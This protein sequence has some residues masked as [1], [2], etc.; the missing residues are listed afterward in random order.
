MSSGDNNNPKQPNNL[1]AVSSSS[2]RVLSNQVQV[3]DDVLKERDP[4]YWYKLGR[5]AKENLNWHKA[6]YCFRR[7]ILLDNFDPITHLNYAYTS[8]VLGYVSL[9]VESV[10]NSI[11]NIKIQGWGPVQKELSKSEWPLILGKIPTESN[12]NS[13][14]ALCRVT[15]YLAVKSEKSL[16]ELIEKV[17]EVHS[18]YLEY[19]YLILGISHALSKNNE[20]ALNAFNKCIEINNNLAFAYRCRGII[21]NLLKDYLGS[22]DD[23]SKLIEFD[24]NYP[25]AYIGRG[26]SKYNLQDYKGA[27]IDYNKAIELNPNEKSYLL[28]RANAYEQLGLNSEA[29]KDRE[30]AQSSA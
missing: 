2:L 30:C 1:P 19:V 20:D 15:I 22:I 8:A 6:H 10:F 25:N 29:E 3:L 26:I 5:S 4:E 11:T 28:K 16:H 23:H 21:K 27:L 18:E 14:V 7:A 17:L 9:V 13:K 12:L 24:A